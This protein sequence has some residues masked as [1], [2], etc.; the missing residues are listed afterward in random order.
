MTEQSDSDARG[1]I[2]YDGTCGFCTRGVPL[3]HPWFRR[4]GLATA[5]LQSDWVGE[6]TGLS[7]EELL[8][9]L[10]LLLGDGRVLRGAD[11]YRWVL[12]QQW[13]SWPLWLVAA[14]PP[15]RWLF[16]GIYRVVA[17]HRHQISAV[18]HLPPKGGR[19]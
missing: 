8:R 1:W 4:L 11:A 19:P 3:A 9:D 7:T 10:T 5:P 12:R 14:V 13:W 16:N 2:L 18:C 6:R 15:G 17:D